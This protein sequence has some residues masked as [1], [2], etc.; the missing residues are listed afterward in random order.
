[1]VNGICVET[2]PNTFALNANAYAYL[3]GAAPE[4]FK[5]GVEQMG[6]YFKL[7]DY[8]RTH[9]QSDLY[10]LTKSPHA[11]AVGR[12]GSTY[13]EAI[14]A[15]PKFLNYFNFAMAT[16]EKVTPILGMFPF[17]SMKE[18]VEADPSRPFAVDIGGGRGQLLLAIQEEAPNGF[19]AK[20]IL[21]DR[22]SVIDPLTSED[23][24]NIEKMSYDFFTP[25]PVKSTV[26]HFN[27]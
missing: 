1:M 6:P 4:F 27:F 3:K 8:F 23:I 9:T 19:G 14:N 25:Q 24:P 21:Q 7:P 26:L 17:S 13:Y 15:D 16:S 20:M 2:A 11:W 18:E 5:F 22:P 10:D 12:E